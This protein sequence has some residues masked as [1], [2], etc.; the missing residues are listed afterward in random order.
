M[1][2]GPAQSTVA[3]INKYQY[4][5]ESVSET[6]KDGTGIHGQRPNP[7]YNAGGHSLDEGRN[8]SLALSFL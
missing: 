8:F 3:S 6:V 1:Y 7:S 5:S 2:L 4:I